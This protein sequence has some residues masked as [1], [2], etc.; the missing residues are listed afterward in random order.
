MLLTIWLLFTHARSPFQYTWEVDLISDIYSAMD[1]G[2]KTILTLFDVSSSFDSVDHSSVI[3]SL[4]DGFPTSSLLFLAPPLG[5]VRSWPLLETIKN[6]FWVHCFAFS[7]SSLLLRSHS[8]IHLL[9]LSSPLLMLVSPSTNCKHLW[10]SFLKGCHIN[11]WMNVMVVS[12]G[13][14]N[15]HDHCLPTQSSYKE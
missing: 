5:S 10:E 8:P 3:P 12:S 14:Q 11:L 9:C 4:L 13:V 15:D 6:Q 7:W 2:Q 1:L